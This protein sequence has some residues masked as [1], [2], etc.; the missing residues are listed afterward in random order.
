MCIQESRGWARVEAL[1]SSF[2]VVFLAEMGDK[3]QLLVMAFAARYHWRPVLGGML[4]GILAVHSLAVAAGNVIG[5]YLNPELMQ[6]IAGAAFLAFGIWTLRGE[7]E[8]DE[9]HDSVRSP[10]WTVATAFFVG[11]MGDKTQFA[12]MTV[13]AAYPS[14][15]LVLT[16]AVLAMV[17]ADLMGVICGALLH[18]RLPE[19]KLQLLSGGIFILFGAVTLIQLVIATF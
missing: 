1:L 13:A 2:G 9:A 10:F 19:K 16:G 3:T 7:A 12:A 11:E 8:E 18:K 5:S 15:Q 6:G 17:L 4:L 14:W